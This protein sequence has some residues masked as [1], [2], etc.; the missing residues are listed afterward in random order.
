MTRIVIADDHP[1]LRRGLI[2]ALEALDDVTVVAEAGD[3]EAAMQAIAQERPDI[4]VLDI[5][6][7]NG[8]GLE[9]AAWAR[10]NAPSVA[11]VLITNYP[12]AAFVERAIELGV[13]GYLLK[14]SAIKELPLC[15]AAAENQG[16]YLS[17]AFVTAAPAELPALD[18]ADTE[19]IGRLTKTQREVLR[20]LAAYKTSKEIARAMGVSFRTVQNHRARIARALGLEGKHRVLEF[21]VRNADRL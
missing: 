19:R 5:A 1:L 9:V 2:D 20:H 11:L 17:P 3:G 21:A 13:C 15:L 18:D 7:P 8:N 6:M 12:D 16:R 10:A 4:A 14:T